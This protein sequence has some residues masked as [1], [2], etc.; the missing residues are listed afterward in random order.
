MR[1]SKRRHELRKYF[2]AM[3]KSEYFKHWF[4]Y[5]TLTRENLIKRILNSSGE[6][7][8]EL[9]GQLHAINKLIEEIKEAEP[10]Q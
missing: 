10:T 7:A 2:K 1:E 6:E 3:S 9:R 8:V 4:E 5:L